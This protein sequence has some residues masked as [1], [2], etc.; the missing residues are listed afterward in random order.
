[1]GFEY[2]AHTRPEL[3]PALLASVFD[4]ISLQSGWY[5]LKREGNT[6]LCLRFS[7]TKENAEWPEDFRLE[8][9]GDSLYVVFYTGS[10]EM[11]R[12]F[13]DFLSDELSTNVEVSG[14]EML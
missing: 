14:F 6:K 5:V 9:D 4:K 10:A 1:M 12:S 11:E 8:V 7:E 3:A 13:L 2:Q